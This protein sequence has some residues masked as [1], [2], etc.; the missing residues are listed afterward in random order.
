VHEHLVIVRVLAAAQVV[1]GQACF[2]E[3]PVDATRGQRGETAFAGDDVAL[4]SI[5]C[6]DAVLLDDDERVRPV[7]M[8]IQDLGLATSD[9]GAFVH[10][11][12]FFY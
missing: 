1:R 8:L 11:P 5:A 4:G 12:S 7:W 10:L 9:L 2:V 6:R 3:Q